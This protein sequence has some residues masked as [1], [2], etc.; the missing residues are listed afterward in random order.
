MLQSRNRQIIKEFRGENCE[1]KLDFLP[2]EA[3]VYFH[4]LSYY[5]RMIARY[6]IRKSIIEG[7]K[8][9]K[10]DIKYSG[11]TLNFKYSK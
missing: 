10:A 7:T 11:K 8:T 4:I 2:Y 9:M 1:K 5:I 6:G 3:E